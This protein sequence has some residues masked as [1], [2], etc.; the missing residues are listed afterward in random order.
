MESHG[1]VNSSLEVPRYCVTGS[2]LDVRT[3]LGDRYVAAVV[4]L[5]EARTA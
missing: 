5:V 4:P 1:P 3:K 2:G